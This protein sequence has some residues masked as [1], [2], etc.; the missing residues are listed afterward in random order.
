MA[1]QVLHGAQVS[2]V[3]AEYGID[4]DEWVSLNVCPLNQAEEHAFGRLAKRASRR[5]QKDLQF[6]LA[7]FFPFASLA[8]SFSGC[9][10]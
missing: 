9:S 4:S 2:G 6:H 8:F 3:S 7:A 1:E 5:D 10:L